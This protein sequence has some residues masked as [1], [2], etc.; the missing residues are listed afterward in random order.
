MYS[1]FLE[2]Y[3]LEYLAESEASTAMSMEQQT[4]PDMACGT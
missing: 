4:A 2:L 1:K 3:V